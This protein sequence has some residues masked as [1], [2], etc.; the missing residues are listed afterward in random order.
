M[1]MASKLWIFRRTSVIMPEDLRNLLKVILPAG[2][3]RQDG[4]MQ[5]CWIECDSSVFYWGND[6][7]RDSG[8]GTVV[9]SETQRPATSSRSKSLPRVG[10][11]D[12][13]FR[14]GGYDRMNMKLNG[15]GTNIPTP[16][17]VQ[18]FHTPCK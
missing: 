15:L 3:G 2:K 8:V 14:R 11:G 16:Y 5:W 9:I 4:G 13:W 17:D 10:S 12:T 1:T 18:E 6:D 7:E